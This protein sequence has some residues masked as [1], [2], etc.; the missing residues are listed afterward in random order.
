MIETGDHLAQ[1]A[2]VNDQQVRHTIQLPVTP[3]QPVAHGNTITVQSIE[4]QLVET[5]EQQRLL[6][7]IRVRLQALP[8]IRQPPDIIAFYSQDPG[9]F[10][11]VQIQHSGDLQH[12]LGQ[13]AGIISD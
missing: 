6:P 8:G 11:V 7:R 9:Q 2:L 13:P 1:A 12:G 5:H 4:K 3:A 10:R